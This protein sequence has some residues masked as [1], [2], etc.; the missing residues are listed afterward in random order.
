VKLVGDGRIFQAPEGFSK[1]LYKKL[2]AR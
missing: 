1:R 2:C